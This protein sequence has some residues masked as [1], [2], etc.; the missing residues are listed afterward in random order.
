MIVLEVFSCPKLTIQ[1]L[2]TKAV[3]EGAIPYL[4]VD[5]QPFG[6]WSAETTFAD[7]KIPCATLYRMNAPPWQKFCYGRI[8]Q[9]NIHP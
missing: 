5:R 1:R 9:F 7:S 4:I 6:L 2:L 8:A 3:F